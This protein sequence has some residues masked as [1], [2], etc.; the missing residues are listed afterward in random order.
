M[1]TYEYL[2]EKCNVVIEHVQPMSQERPTWKKCPKCG[3]RA[4]QEIITPPAVATSGMDT[5]SVDV[6]IGRDAAARWK[7]IHERQEVRNKARKESGKTALTQTGKDTY[8]G[9]DKKLRFVP[10]S[11][12]KVNQDEK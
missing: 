3:G 10:I 8:V 7:V 9:T 4:Y 1:A 12:S 5:V 2:C 6:A 11:P